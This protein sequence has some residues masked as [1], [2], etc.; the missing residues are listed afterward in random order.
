[1]D[2]IINELSVNGSYTD[3]FEASHGMAR[4]MKLANKLSGCGLTKII[5]TTR[6]FSQRE[7]SFRYTVHDWAVDKNA[8]CAHELRHYYLTHTAKSPYIEEFI[9]EHEDTE[10]SC[11]EYTYL[12]EQA[13]GLG[14]AHI[15]NSAALSLDGDPA[16]KVDHV[17]LQKT[18]LSH[19]TEIVSETVKATSIWSIDQ[20]AKIGQALQKQVQSSVKT[21]S[22]LV[23]KVGEFFPLLKFSEHTKTQLRSLYGSE[24]FFPE[25]VTHLSILNKTMNNWN[26]GHFEPKGIT[27]SGESKPTIERYGDCRRFECV[28]GETRLFAMHTKMMS[29]NQRIHYCPILESKI[30]HIGYVGKHLPTIEHNT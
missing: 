27:F 5:R 26:G 20:V 17:S 29:S 14:L 18:T 19:T 30:V 15:W 21:G 24:Q 23:E 25:I 12:D 16:F 8:P 3:K 1:M 9:Q 28:D 2:Q 4:C 10:Q 7:L 11:I 6:D 22:E 13:Y